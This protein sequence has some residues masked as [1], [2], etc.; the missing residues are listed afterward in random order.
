MVVSP[1]AKSGCT[2]FHAGTPTPLSLLDNGDNVF[3]D[4]V[5]HGADDIIRSWAQVNAF[6]LEAAIFCSATRHGRGSGH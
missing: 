2:M 5:P 3:L 6:N 4:V 1:L